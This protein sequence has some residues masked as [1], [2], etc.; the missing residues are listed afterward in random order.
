MIFKQDV[1]FSELANSICEC[2]CEFCGTAKINLTHKN[3]DCLMFCKS[4]NVN[5]FLDEEINSE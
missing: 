4:K 5:M 2:E 3:I 1:G